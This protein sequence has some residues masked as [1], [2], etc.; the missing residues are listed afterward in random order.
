MVAMAMETIV[1]LHFPVAWP[2][3]PG[4]DTCHCYM[5]KQW[6]TSVSML[7]CRGEMRHAKLYCAA[8]HV[9]A[10]DMPNSIP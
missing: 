1:C 4:N 8:Y 2:F 3:S 6:R 9:M 5:L 10:E 7:S